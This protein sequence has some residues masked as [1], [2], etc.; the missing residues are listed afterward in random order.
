MLLTK[1]EKSPGPQDRPTVEGSE[2]LQSPRTA[3]YKVT[4]LDPEGETM[5]Q[6]YGALFLVRYENELNAEIIDCIPRSVAE[7][8]KF[9][10]ILSPLISPVFFV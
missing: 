1:Q 10:M 2:N 7:G 8:W 5:R 3:Y 9:C 6:E 4:S